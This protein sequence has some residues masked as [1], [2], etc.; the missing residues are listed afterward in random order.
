[1]CLPCRRLHQLL[2]AEWQ[3][4]KSRCRRIADWYNRDP[5]RCMSRG[6][7]NKQA[8]SSYCTH[9]TDRFCLLLCLSGLFVD[10]GYFVWIYIQLSAI[11]RGIHIVLKIPYRFQVSRMDN[12]PQWLQYLSPVAA[13]AL[14][15][16]HSGINLMGRYMVGS[17]GSS[18]L[19]FLFEKS[20]V[21][22]I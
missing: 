3:A 9:E 16:G 15:A 18:Q 20:W 5:E 14:K 19:N 10:S 12:C 22:T 17:T 11:S 13:T 4:W 21:A 1:M 7:I 6:K 2:L 8:L